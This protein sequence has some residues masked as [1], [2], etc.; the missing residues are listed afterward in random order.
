MMDEQS[1]ARSLRALVRRV[2]R[3]PFFLASALKVYAES[4]GMNDEDLAMLLGCKTE[5]LDPLRLC[6][7]PSSESPSFRG[8]VQRIAGH[9]GLKADGLAR[10]LRQVDVLA[11]L[12]Q[13]IPEG[14]ELRAARDREPES[15][16]SGDER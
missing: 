7:R 3:E 6:R 10:I 11:V 8:E 9:F 14:A 15:E 5:R 16:E 12:R 1:K 4:E 13:G 2:E